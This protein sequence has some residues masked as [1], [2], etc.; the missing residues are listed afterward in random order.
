M[1]SPVF[2]KVRTRPAAQASCGSSASL[3]VSAPPERT[4]ESPA[5]WLFASAGEIVTEDPVLETTVTFSCA[6]PVPTRST[7]PTANWSAAATVIT[8]A[9]PA[10]VPA[11]VVVSV[12]FTKMVTGTTVQ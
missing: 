11:S 7:S 5:P 8:V 6:G 12:V 1:G 2:P 3:Y 4:T 9:P 10:A